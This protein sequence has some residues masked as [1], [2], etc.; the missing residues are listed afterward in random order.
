MG[1][2][3]GTPRPAARPT[4]GPPAT[5]ANGTRAMPVCGGEAADVKNYSTLLHRSELQH[6]AAPVGPGLG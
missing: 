3:A 1:A 2:P 6:T 4:P 5:P